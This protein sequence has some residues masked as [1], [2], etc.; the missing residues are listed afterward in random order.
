[1]GEV[2]EAV[3]VPVAEVAA[4]VPA[5]AGARLLGLQV[6]VVA[7]EAGGARHVDDLTDR[8]GIEQSPVLVEAGRRTLIGGLGIDNDGLVVRRTAERSRRHVRDAGDDRA[9]LAG[10]VALDDA[11][12]EAPFELGDVPF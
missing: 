1:A 8:F 5:V 7:L 9:T 3:L 10:P 11:A 2:E 4:P 12:S 6:V